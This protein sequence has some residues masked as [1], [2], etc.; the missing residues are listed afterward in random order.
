[1]TASAVRTTCMLLGLILL[2]H[3]SVMVVDP[4]G[5]HTGATAAELD[6]TTDGHHR[7]DHPGGHDAREGA[8]EVPVTVQPCTE[9]GAVRLASRLMPEPVV[10]D[11]LVTQPMA[12]AA[13]VASL[14]IQIWEP[15]VVSGGSLRAFLQVYLN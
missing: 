12:G 3:I 13:H 14:R 11:L 4:N 6:A 1:M 15:P 2:A 5:M 10:L 7:M 9:T 8:G